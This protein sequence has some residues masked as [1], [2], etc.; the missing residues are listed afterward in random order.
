L[1]DPNYEVFTLAIENIKGKLMEADDNTYFF[2]KSDQT[3]YYMREIKRIIDE[4]YEK[5]AERATQYFD[6]LNQIYVKRKEQALHTLDEELKGIENPEIIMKQIQAKRE[7]AE[8][9][10]KLKKIF[11]KTINTDCIKEQV[12]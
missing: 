10:T 3:S 9:I 4:D 5:S 6:V 8:E 11:E 7:S 1:N 12:K 2:N